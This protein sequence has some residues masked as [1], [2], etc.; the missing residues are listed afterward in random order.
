MAQVHL[1]QHKIPHALVGILKNKG[2]SLHDKMDAPTRVIDFL[3]DKEST[4]QS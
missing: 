1:C 2:K 4:C 3:P